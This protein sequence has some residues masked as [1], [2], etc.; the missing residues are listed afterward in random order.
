MGSAAPYGLVRSDT[1]STPLRPPRSRRG[2][3][4]FPPPACVARNARGCLTQC[5]EPAARNT[6]R[7]KLWTPRFNPELARCEFELC[8]RACAH[9]CPAGLMSLVPDAEVK[10]GQ[11]VISN[12]R[13]IVWSQGK[14]CLICYER[15]RY[16]AI[17]VDEKR[18]PYMIPENCT[19]CGA[20]QNTCIAEPAKA[21][22]VYPP[23]HV[24]SE[25]MAAG[26]RRRRP[27]QQLLT[28][29]SLR[30]K[31]TRKGRCAKSTDSPSMKPKPAYHR[32][33]STS[34]SMTAMETDEPRSA[35]R[36]RR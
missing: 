15:C 19:G 18:R 16:Q 30:R 26:R 25:G 1:R 17:G 3:R 20:C 14:D 23:G 34:A 11:A 21:I 35:G 6:G 24:P 2:T 8:G 29:R 36:S 31:R 5:L 13:C 9:A 27:Q 7:A 32:F 22:I 10:L 4:G 28:R 12:K 33:N